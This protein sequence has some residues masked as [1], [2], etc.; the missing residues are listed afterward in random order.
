M[1]DS[2]RP[3][4]AS[5]VG[6]PTETRWGQVLQTPHAYGVVE[7]HAPD[8]IARTR[9]IQL[10]TKLTR[11]FDI[12]P[13]SLAALVDIAET[14]IHDDV[15]SL[16]LLVPIGQTLYI[17][18]KG[19][20]AVYLKRGDQ[21]AKL[22]TS[23]GSL[24]GNMRPGDT[25]IAATQSFLGTLSEQEIIGAFD[26]LRPHEVAEKLTIRL[27][28]RQGGEGGAAL[29]FEMGKPLDTE[30][31]EKIVPS[32][33][34]AP[35]AK[36]RGMMIPTVKA[37]IRRITP[38]S[39]RAKARILIHKVRSHPSFSVKR[40][41][42]VI[43]ITLF[44]ASVAL[45]IRRQQTVQV[46]SAVTDAV[47]TAKHSFDEGMAL[48]ELNPVKGRERLTSARDTLAPL[49]ARKSRSAELREARQLYEEVVK[50]LTRA[51]HSVDVQP[52]LYFD[53]G[54]LKKDAKATDISLFDETIGIY[55]AF[56]KT[57]Y[58]LG[59][60]N[61]NGN[62][63]GGGNGFDNASH[64]A[65]YGDKVYVWTPTGIHQIRLSDQ[66]TVPNMIPASSEWGRISDMAVFGGNIYL[67]DT[68]KSR[69][70]KY[71]ATEKGFSQ[72]F[73]YLNPDTLPD[74]SQVT[75]LAIDG[76][77]WLGTTNGT[78]MRF[79]AGKENSYTPQ[80]HDMPLGKRLSVYTHD[81][82]KMVYVLDHDYHRVVVFDKEGMY[83]AQYVWRAG[84]QPTALA[85]SESS[86]KLFLLAEGKI[87]ATDLK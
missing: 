67:L 32:A 23:D 59:V 26:H 60:T 21:L 58:T 20:G 41:I 4:V 29:I 1:A 16:V 86:R 45:G 24:S 44:L 13:V 3:T 73:E 65:V 82:L 31:E 43:V 50:N 14:T 85:V 10:L 11:I 62:I 51:M 53:M 63:V 71:V 81:E 55:D 76:S 12:P 28:E 54:L 17:V 57:V 36:R 37:I 56:G 70:W 68:Q 34:I 46:Q 83:M 30:Q 52:E 6:V 74:L 80:G 15:V 33:T 27:H 40:F 66:K 77:V 48:L 35:T 19:N 78:I 47:A 61:R 49:I 9:G 18:S 5:V 39:G 72:L 2:V 69:I 64:V 79:T 84:F 8:G 22:L 87:Y 38:A 42:A 25:I 75:N 7:V